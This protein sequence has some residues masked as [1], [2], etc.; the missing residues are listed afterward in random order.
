MTRDYEH[1]RPSMESVTE[2]LL[3]LRR[4]LRPS[5]LRARLVP[6]NEDDHARLKAAVPHFCRTVWGV[7]SGAD[8]APKTHT[9]RMME[10]DR[11]MEGD[12]GDE[13]EEDEREVDDPESDSD[14][15]E[16]GSVLERPVRQQHESE[17]EHEKDKDD[18]D[19]EEKEHD[20]R[21]D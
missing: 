15:E 8:P 18:D 10:Q 11:A 16:T 20:P 21:K 12:A 19:D 7:A 1:D 14:D 13:D 6:R 4:A 2:Q 3:D 5:A 17:E 9:E